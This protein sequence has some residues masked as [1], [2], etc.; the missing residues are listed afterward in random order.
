M[1]L[2]PD[3]VLA[4]KVKDR[5]CNI[6][7]YLIKKN[8]KDLIQILVAHQN[9]MQPPEIEALLEAC[10][11]TPLFKLKIFFM[12]LLGQFQNCLTQFFQI[13]AIKPDVFLWLNEI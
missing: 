7:T 3:T 11:S 12:Q 9:S 1:E 5:T 4:R 2:V 6:Y 10:M 13:K 8:E